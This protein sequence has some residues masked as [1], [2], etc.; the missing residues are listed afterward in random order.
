MEFPELEARDLGMIEAR[1]PFDLLSCFR[2]AGRCRIPPAPTDVR[3][4]DAGDSGTQLSN[5]LEAEDRV[6]MVKLDTVTQ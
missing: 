3:H 6:E 2:Y 4:G 1:G 5:A